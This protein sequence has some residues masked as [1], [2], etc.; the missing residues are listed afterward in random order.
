MTT[1]MSVLLLCRVVR[2]LR[3]WRVILSA[4]FAHFI[5]KAYLPLSILKTMEEAEAR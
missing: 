5:R 2:G 3:R 4:H 1:R